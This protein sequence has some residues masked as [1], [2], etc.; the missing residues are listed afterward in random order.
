M[1][2]YSDLFQMAANEARRTAGHREARGVPWA[3]RGPD[4]KPGYWSHRLQNVILRRLRYERMCRRNGAHQPQSSRV[5]FR[6]T[7][8]EE[9]KALFAD[10]PQHQM[11][12]RQKES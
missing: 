11:T 10:F 2:I 6:S 8:R 9:D 4:R 1:T 3:V 12:L 7:L 5:F